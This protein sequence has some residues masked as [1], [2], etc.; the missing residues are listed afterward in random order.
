M[1]IGDANARLLLAVTTIA[2]G[3]FLRRIGL[4][5]V[6]VGKSL[7]K[8]LFNATLPSV[9]LMSIFSV[10]FDA[11]SAAV[12]AC[13]LGQAIVLLI[14]HLAF[15]GQG[16]PPKELALL[17]GSCVG[18][19]LGTFCYPLVESVWGSEGLTRVVLFD[20]VNQWSLLIVAP[21]IYA[22]SIAG[23]S[24]SPVKALAN[25]K[26]QL[27]SPCLLAMFTAIALRLAGLSLPEPVAAFTSS[28]AL[29][30]KPL[31]L[32]ALG[33]LFDPQLN[34][35]QLKDIGTLLALRYGACLLLGAAVM[36][37]L[38]VSMGPECTAVVLAALISPVPLLTVTYAMEYDCDIK[39][40]ASAVNAGN[41]CSFG[42]LLAVANTNLTNATALAPAVA[43][44]GTALALV[45]VL[46]ARG[47]SASRDQVT[48]VQANAA[49]FS[50]RRGAQVHDR[51]QLEVRKGHDVGFAGSLGAV[52]VR[53]QIAKG[54]AVRPK[55]VPFAARIKTRECITSNRVQ[56]VARLVA[57]GRY[58]YL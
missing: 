28:L 56:A 21:L 53:V 36:A 42:L 44:A 51:R 37:T 35:S 6:D 43:A 4:V 54:H 34:K 47:K 26:K 22:S 29:A 48:P 15:R 12:S 5:D 24:F 58:A 11:Q 33:I 25:V 41:F 55:R 38:S 45:G 30:N 39:L 9:L 50:R 57:T 46:G 3:N 20:A 23:A 32:L 18:V 40:S 7:L 31:A 8:V 16:R 17:A 1:P 13:A 52:N 27:M 49:R 2:F 19:N 10:T 14:A